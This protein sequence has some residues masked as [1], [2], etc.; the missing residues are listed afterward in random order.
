MPRSSRQDLKKKDFLK[1][2]DS[3]NRITKVI[4]PNPLQVGLDDAEFRSGLIVK[5][6]LEVSQ[7][8]TGSITQVA[9]GV[10]FIQGGS[11]VS[12]TKNSDGSLT[13]AAT[14][15]ASDPLTI[16]DGLTLDTGT[17]YD[18]TNARTL[19]VNLATNRGL[20]FNG[21]GELEIDIRNSVAGT[22]ATNSNLLLET[23]AGSIFKATL[24]DV[25]AL[26]TPS[27]L[28]N[29]LQFGGGI[30]G[31]LGE[32][33]Y[34]N[35]SGVTIQ[36][37]TASNGGLTI[38]AGLLLVDPND[39]VETTTVDSANDY[40]L[41]YD[42]SAS[43]LRKVTAGRI[44]SILPNGL[45]FGDGLAPIGS[46][47]D[48]SVP[49]TLEVTASNSTINVTPAGISVAS[50][51]AQL[52][53]SK[54]VKTFSYNGSTTTGVELDLDSAGGLNFDTVTDTL[55]LDI[56]NLVGGPSPT[57]VDEIAV[58]YGPNDTR[59]IEIGALAGIIG[60]GGS[61]GTVWF[62]GGDK[63]YSTSSISIDPEGRFAGEIGTDVHFYISGTIGAPV[64][65]AKI[66]VFGGDVFSS[67]SITATNLSGSLT[68]LADGTPYLVAGPNIT[69]TTASNGSIEI[70][71]SAGGSISVVSGSDSVSG[72]TT[73]NTDQLGNI[74]DLGGGVVAITGS[75][76]NA[77]DGTYLDGLF[78]DFNSS[79]PVGTAVDRFNEVLKGLAPSAAPA[80]DDINCAD[81]GA[82]AKLSFGSTQSIAGYT[83]VEPSTL[84]PASSLSDIDINGTFQVQSSGG[85]LRR[86][87]FAGNTTINGTLNSD[88]AAD[89][90]NYPAAA[91]GNGD[92]G[93]LKLFVNDTSTEIHSTDLSTFGS[94]DSLNVSGSGFNLSAVEPGHF[95]D[96]T[97]FDTFK[98]RTGTY[99]IDPDDQREGW[100]YALVIHTIGTSD[101]VTNYVEWV[102]DPD[103]NALSADTFAF[104]SLAM[105]GLRKLSGARYFT[106]GTA[107]Y[108]ARALNAYRNIYPTTNITFN[109][110]RCSVPSQGFPSIDFGAGEDETKQLHIT[111]SATIN[112]DPILNNSISVSLN[113]PAVLKSNLSGVGSQSING[114][115]LYNLSNTSTVT[116][117][118]FR[119]ENYRLLSGSY[120][121]QSDVID[122]A[123]SWDSDV[124]MSG[125]N[126]GYQDGL[127]YYNSSLR[128]PTAGA[129]S[130]DF[131]N[132][133]DG[134]S[135]IN[136]PDDNV[137]YSGI[138]T[139]LRTFYRYI[140]NNSGGS[141]SNFSLTINGS[142]TIVNQSTAL[143][144]NR[145]H[146]LLKI[147]T[148][149]VPFSTGWMDL[150]V[151][152]ATGDTGDGDGCLQ[153]TLDSSL[154]ATNTGT[155]GVESVGSNEYIM[156]KIEADASWTGNISSMSLTWT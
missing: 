143:T 91:I 107:E 99:T 79:T 141:K 46:S 12:V 17:E 72:I 118:T 26:S 101:S 56:N 74:Q 86:A 35:S 92:Q 32:T 84:T 95:P 70:T 15:F 81:S 151:D 97:D 119:S 127:L 156:V 109:G 87:C 24:N 111:G 4:S 152:F 37:A 45:T 130:G 80:L 47:Y 90:P 155:F 89:T 126:A 124:H 103:A 23:P 150:A 39:A 7:G 36:V 136:G 106:A 27:T 18:G 41:I 42:A 71:G 135:I 11:N 34:D 146:V 120:D 62:D 57:T 132:T 59:K 116:S 77:E 83:N 5:G 48:G 16:S 33:Q 98:H 76:G 19:T 68:T 49:I 40:L 113:V 131:R 100:N 14:G 137:D 140:Q 115:L 121:N 53:A 61:G 153:G 63:A 10:D 54:G 148:T 128:A 65:D 114:I 75:I 142:G 104:D 8:I 13:L 67:G 30:E 134:G 144:G 60:G 147:P 38:D 88:V 117:E 138:T 51:P 29:P 52:T 105:T 110:T 20:E 96:G 22:A 3:A 125:S 28:G 21:S 2:V 93:I 102:N 25:L 154:N 139:G 1:L 122:A 6:N 43:G 69:I 55:Q 66:T 58:S 85:D 82:T 108:R 73:I 9:D 149:S 129:V 50:L 64:G 123:N 145:I 133:S 44:G 31:T 94:G 78:T 112:T